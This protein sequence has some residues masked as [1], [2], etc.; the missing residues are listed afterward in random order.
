[1]TLSVWLTSAKLQLLSR[2][3]NSFK[4]SKFCAIIHVCV[5][6]A[7]HNLTGFSESVTI[8]IILKFLSSSIGHSNLAADS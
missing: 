5:F 7:R 4:L 6:G 3:E 8:H 2:S 1:M